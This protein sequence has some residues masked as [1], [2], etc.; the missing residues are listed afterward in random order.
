MELVRTIPDGCDEI[1]LQDIARLGR[2][3]MV[4][5]MLGRYPLIPFRS[6]C[7]TLVYVGYVAS[8]R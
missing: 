2:V 7:N 1:G 8:P 6:T 4:S 3:V 5:S